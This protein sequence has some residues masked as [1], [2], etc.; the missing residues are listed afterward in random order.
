MTA[1]ASRTE[2]HR[3]YPYDRQNQINHFKQSLIPLIGER[4]AK[5]SQSKKSGKKDGEK[6]KKLS[7]KQLKEHVENTSTDQLKK[8]AEKQDHP[9]NDAAKREL[10]RRG[11]T[12]KE[13]EFILYKV[14]PKKLVWQ[15][16]H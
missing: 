7:T 5:D 9:H 1:I 6:E 15:R 13:E 3:I 16:R 2:R 8:V 14:P 10:E 4:F 11:E 12:K